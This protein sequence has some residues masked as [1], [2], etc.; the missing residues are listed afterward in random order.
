MGPA[1]EA[2]GLKVGR[3][4]TGAL[5]RAFVRFGG[6]AQEAMRVGLTMAAHPEIRGIAQ[7]HRGAADAATNKRLDAVIAVVERR[8]KRRAK[9]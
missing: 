8:A 5:V 6:E 9:R 3:I 1:R 2:E 7:Q 4:A